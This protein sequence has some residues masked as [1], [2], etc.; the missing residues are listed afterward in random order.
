VIDR[1]VLENFQS[2]ES[3]DLPLSSIVVIVGE[4]D[5]GKSA[6]MRALDAVLY[7]GLEGTS[8]VRR[9]AKV[10]AVE[11]HTDGHAVRLEKGVGVNRY[12]VDGK[13][14]DKI[15]RTVPGAVQDVLH[16][17]EIVFDDD[18]TLT[19]Q[20]QPQ[21]DAP[22]LLADQGVKATRLLGSVTKVA[23]LYQAARTTTTKKKG[24]MASVQALAGVLT[25]AEAR[26]ASYDYLDTIQEDMVL[27]QVVQDKLD[28]V[29]A[30]RQRLVE[31]TNRMH[32]A[33]RQLG[34]L[35]EERNRLLGILAK[36][37]RL[38]IL[39]LRRDHLRASQEALQGLDARRQAHQARVAETRQRRD[40]GARQVLGLEHLEL[41]RAE[42]ARLGTAGVALDRVRQIRQVCREAESRVLVA[43][44]VYAE[45]QAANL[46]P[47][48]GNPK[49]R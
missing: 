16:V 13:V 12:L 25:Q 5:Q 4:T 14:Y 7:N 21:M 42:R 39:L 31:L 32:E 36:L 1:L 6:L 37:D 24:A 15:A 34:E 49:V 3:L 22:F 11:L 28:Q 26:V 46:C 17:R 19:L 8:F 33:E 10:A 47:T 2:W 18:T 41:V 20:F 45:A 43:R 38:D 44:A 48:C 27:L 23:T 29:R 35:A 30:E 40:Q 9:G